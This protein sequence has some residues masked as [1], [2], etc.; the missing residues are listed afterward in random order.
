MEI[1]NLGTVNFRDTAGSIAS[2]FSTAAVIATVF[3]VFWI[4]IINKF[5]IKQVGYSLTLAVVFILYSI[6]ELVKSNGAI[7]VL[8]FALL[9]SNFGDIT[10]R[11]KIKGEFTL[12]TT[13]R[14]FQAEVSFFVRTFFFIFIGLMFNINTLSSTGLIMAVVVFLTIIFSRILCVRALIMKD[15]KMAPY[16]NS[17]ISMMPRGLAA[18]VLASMPLAAGIKIPY[19]IYRNST[20]RGF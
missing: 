17:M 15:K 13:L 6:V 3:A 8:V 18:A 20:W 14:A 19:F 12:D 1:I 5:Y 7:A 10:K 11:L 2:A 9:L 16:E 4:G